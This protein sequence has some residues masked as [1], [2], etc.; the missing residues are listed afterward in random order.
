MGVSQQVRLRRSNLGRSDAKDACVESLH[1]HH[2]TTVTRADIPNSGQYT[3][4]RGDTVTRIAERFGI[5][6]K[7]ILE[8]NNLRNRNRIYV[9][10][11]L[12]LLAETTV[13]GSPKLMKTKV[14]SVGKSKA[15]APKAPS[16]SSPK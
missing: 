16:K 12:S 1:S 9:G 10:Q 4:R 15:A 14:S 8:V 13:A 7:Q 6:E 5:E 11:S 2:K 3:V